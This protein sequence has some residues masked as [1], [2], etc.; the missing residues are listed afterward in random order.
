M[1]KKSPRAA[2]KGEGEALPT[3]KRAKRKPVFTLKP[4]QVIKACVEAKRALVCAGQVLVVMELMEGSGWNATELSKRSGV[5]RSH[6]SDFLLLKKFVTTQIIYL[7]A[8]AFDLK[9][10]ALDDLAEKRVGA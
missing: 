8:R 3:R 6:L 9:L 4:E 10:S 5:S 7:L 1:K 2:R